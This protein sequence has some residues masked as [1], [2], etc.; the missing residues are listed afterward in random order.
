MNPPVDPDDIAARFSHLPQN[1]RGAGAEMN[2]RHAFPL[3]SFKNQLDMRHHIFGI[4]AGRETADP[5]IEQLNR[6]SAGLDL[7]PE[8]AG[9]A[10]AQT[11]P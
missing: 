3:E 9:D 8:I 4:V 10:P 11:C 5:T 2:H 7:P 1:R 6:L